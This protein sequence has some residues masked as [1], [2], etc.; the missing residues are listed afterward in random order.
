MQNTP[1]APDRRGPFDRAWLL[2]MFPA[3]F[4]SGNAIVGRA[5]AG[6]VPPIALAFWRWVVGAAIVLPFAWRHL[7]ADLPAMRRH[8]RVMLALSVLGVA[9]FNT[10]LYI[11][12]Q[13]TTALNIVMLQTAMPV[14]IVLAS[15]LMFREGVSA[16]QGIGIAVS[17][18]G[19][20]VLITHGDPAVLARLALNRGDVWMLAGIASYAA[21]TA[22]LRQRPAVHGL[23]FVAATFV[24][25]AALLLPFHVAETLAGRPLPLTA[26]ALL[27][28]LY[29]AVFASVLAYLCYNRVV[30]LVGANTAGLAV[31][32]VPVFG[33]ILAILLLG[34]RPRAY[35]AIGIGLIAAGIWLAQRRARRA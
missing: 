21:Y 10:C 9:V 19:A 12:A 26:P 16:R 1:Q 11:A 27:A 34:E 24:T 7:Q 18:A 35:H 17:L 22:L 28:I 31:P 29:V 4:W 23:S 13:T 2:M 32:L 15:F 3:L 14:L 25:G 6:E 8:W 20:L 33:T 30:A 5:V